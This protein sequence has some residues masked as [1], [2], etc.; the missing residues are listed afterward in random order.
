MTFVTITVDGVDCVLE[1]R[2][3]PNHPVSGRVAV[4]VR[5][6]TLVPFRKRSSRVVCPSV[7]VA[8]MPTMVTSFDTGEAETK[9]E[10]A[11]D[12]D[13]N[14]PRCSCEL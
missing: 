12:Y 7:S 11:T 4:S 8:H 10:T 5:S 6:A 14:R 13:L 1:T 2:M 3:P 9:C